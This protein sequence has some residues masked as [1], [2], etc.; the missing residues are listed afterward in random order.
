MS[1]RNVGNEFAFER[2]ENGLFDLTRFNSEFWN[3]FENFLEM[4]YQRD[5]IVQLEIWDPWDHYVD[6]Q[7]FGGWSTQPVQPRQQ[8]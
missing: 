4:A 2:D 6:H 5:L 1:H 3:R 7:S 8:Y